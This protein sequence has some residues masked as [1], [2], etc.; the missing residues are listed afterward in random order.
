MSRRIID[1]PHVEPKLDIECDY[2]IIMHYLDHAFAPYIHNRIEEAP[3]C[4]SVRL[5]E[6]G[7]KEKIIEINGE[8]SKCD[9][10]FIQY[11]GRFLLRNAKVEPHFVMLHGGGVVYNNQAFLFLGESMAGKSTLIAHLTMAG[12]EYISD[13][14]LLINLLRKTVIPFPKTIILR[15][16]GSAILKQLHGCKVQTRTFLHN[17]VH[18]EFFSPGNCSKKETKIARIFIISRQENIEIEHMRI[19]AKNAMLELLK[20]NMAINDC[21]N[22]KKFV[23]LSKVPLEKMYYSNMDDVCKI[24]EYYGRKDDKGEEI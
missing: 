23:D 12:F 16:Q 2:D 7:E 4:V 8:K 21:T 13:D 6:N 10:G 11:I 18:K 22:I 19:D 17:N 15:P 14:R 20:Y 5:Y 1:M 3:K 24:V 9:I